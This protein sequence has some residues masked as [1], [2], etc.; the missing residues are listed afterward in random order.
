[1]IQ[2]AAEWL[3]AVERGVHEFVFAQTFH[4]VQRILAASAQ[5]S[6]P[7]A[8]RSVWTVSEGT[9]RSALAH[10]NLWVQ[11]I[12]PQWAGLRAGNGQGDLERRLSDRPG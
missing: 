9:R 10:A 12:C 3:A 7:A 4:V 6:R 2:V 1:M 8:T 5:G 11:E